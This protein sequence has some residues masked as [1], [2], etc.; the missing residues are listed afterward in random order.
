MEDLSKL[1]DELTNNDSFRKPFNSV[2]NF[3][4]ESDILF[5]GFPGDL[6][7]FHQLK[8]PEKAIKRK[9]GEDLVVDLE[10]KLGAINNMILDHGSKEKM[11]ETVREKLGKSMQEL[12]LFVSDVDLELHEDVK[13]KFDIIKE[14]Y[15]NLGT[16]LPG[17]QSKKKKERK[18][19]L[20]QPQIVLLFHHLQNLGMITKDLPNRTLAACISEITGFTAEQIRQG[21]SSVSLFSKNIDANFKPADY[22]ALYLKV[23]ALQENLELEESKRFE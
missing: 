5:S 3:S 20:T 11:I 18:V 9:T 1:L 15:E 8:R 6:G 12:I 22:S 21:L 2:D 19:E 4:R 7:Q 10:S 13:N 16:K 14:A 23:N 17:Y